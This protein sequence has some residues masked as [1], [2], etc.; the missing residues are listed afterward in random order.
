MN[1]DQ[2]S[3]TPNDDDVATALS[4]V[5]DEAGLVAL[6]SERPELFG[7]ES[8]NALKELVTIPG[9]GRTVEPYLALLEDLPKGIQGAWRRFQS[10]MEILSE[11][12]DRLIS[13]ILRGREL[14]EQGKFD[15][16]IE[17]GESAIPVA[18]DQGH[19]VWAA[20]LH[21]LLATCFR[22]RGHQVRTDLD[23]AIKPDSPLVTTVRCDRSLP[24]GRARDEPCGP[25]RNSTQ[26]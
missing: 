23:E 26:R 10:S 13:I 3:S 7:A 14:A 24:E 5:E 19:W 21:A 1:F 17:L 22:L 4:G 6:V 16:A 20:E 15:E 8:I 11:E 18:Y 12:I 2:N 25:L 9:A